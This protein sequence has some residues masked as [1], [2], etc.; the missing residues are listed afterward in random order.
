MSL[1]L[2]G[3]TL[4]TLSLI[5]V[6]VNG[7]AVDLRCAGR[8][9]MFGAVTL[10]LGAHVGQQNFEM[11]EMRALWRW[12]D[13][14]GFD[15]LSAWDHIY[16]APPAGGTIPHFEAVATLAAL[17]VETTNARLGCLVFYVGYRNPGL[18]AKAAI[19]IDHLSGGRFELGIGAGWH[20]WEAEAYGYDFPP[21]GK[22]L[23][24]LDEA[25]RLIGPL[26]GASRFEESDTAG[27]DPKR[28]TFAGH[29]FRLRNA[30]CLPP[31]AYGTMPLW[32]GGVGENRTLPMTARYADGWNAAYVSAAE[33]G[34]LNTL[35]DQRC[36]D[37]DRDPG[38]VERSVNLVFAMGSDRRQAERTEADLA[39]QWGSMAERIMGGALLGTPEQAVERVAAYAEAGADMVNVALRAPFER[40]ALDA[41]HEVVM[42]QVRAMTSR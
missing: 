24:M 39:S 31:P 15:W 23:D 32:F 1:R 4:G 7:R 13:G 28:T 8:F 16:E 27:D 29:Y 12:L 22:R 2:D 36:Q 40:E 11:D 25:A 38:A 34:R 14:N 20:E 5:P 9:A 26:I 41:Y 18:L 37:L 6:A 3:F 42:P 17:A 30:S 10:L 21:V 19:T 33:Y 35:L